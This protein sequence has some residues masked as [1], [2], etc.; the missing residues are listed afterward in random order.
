MKDTLLARSLK[1]RLM[2]RGDHLRREEK[3][4]LN[5]MLSGNSECGPTMRRWKMWGRRWDTE[6]REREKARIW[7]EP[8]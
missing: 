4:E 1:D 5:E 2:S 8:N 3:S 7:L 6:K